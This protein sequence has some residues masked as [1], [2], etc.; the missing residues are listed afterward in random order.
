[1]A[2][3]QGLARIKGEQIQQIQPE[4]GL[5]SQR[6]R[7][8]AASGDLLWLGTEKSIQFINTAMVD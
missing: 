1:L 7:R 5:F 6:I 2:T 3:T 8:L 4:S